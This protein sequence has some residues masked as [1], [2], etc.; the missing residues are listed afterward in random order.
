MNPILIFH[1][2]SLGNQKPVN[3][4]FE[5]PEFRWCQLGGMKI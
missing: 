4:R 2:S 1:I 3:I 5:H